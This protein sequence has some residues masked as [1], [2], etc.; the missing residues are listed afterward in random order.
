MDIARGVGEEAVCKVLEQFTKEKTE[1][2]QVRQQL[3]FVN[4]CNWS[5]QFGGHNYDLI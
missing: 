3:W 4:N 1:L 5:G 2:T